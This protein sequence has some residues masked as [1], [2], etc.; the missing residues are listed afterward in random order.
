VSAILVVDLELNFQVL[1]LLRGRS[2]HDRLIV[3]AHFGMITSTNGTSGHF[4]SASW[5]PA[6]PGPGFV[7]QT[8]FQE[9]GIPLDLPSSI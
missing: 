2:T 8:L 6:G 4:K 1:G 5:I 9:K 3:E 7:D